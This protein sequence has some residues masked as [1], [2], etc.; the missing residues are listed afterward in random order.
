MITRSQRIKH[1]IDEF[2]ADDESPDT[3]T[4]DDTIIHNQ[5]QGGIIPQCPTCGMR[6]I[7]GFKDASLIQCPGCMTSVDL[8]KGAFPYTSQVSQRSR[9]RYGS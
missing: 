2:F 8:A 9:G 3:L 6:L 4:P 7:P 5:R 1:L